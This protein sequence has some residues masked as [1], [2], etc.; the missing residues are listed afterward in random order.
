MYRFHCFEYGNAL[1]SLEKGKTLQH[2]LLD[3]V[4]KFTSFVS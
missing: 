3:R 4:A 2:F 1:F